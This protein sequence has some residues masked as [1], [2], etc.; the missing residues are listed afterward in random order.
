MLKGLQT[1]TDEPW[2]RSE[3]LNY[4]RDAHIEWSRSHFNLVNSGAVDL[5]FFSEIESEAINKSEAMGNRLLQQQRRKEA[6]RRRAREA[7]IRAEQRAEEEARDV[8]FSGNNC[9]AQRRRL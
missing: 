8:S 3:D 2:K 7:A 9:R 1:I 4:G 5:N 6:A